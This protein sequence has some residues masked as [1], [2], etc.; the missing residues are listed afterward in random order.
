MCMYMYMCTG[1]LFYDIDNSLLHFKFRFSTQDGLC[2]GNAKEVL[3]PSLPGGL[4]DVGKRRFEDRSRI[5]HILWQNAST[6]SNANSSTS[7]R[8]QGNLSGDYLKAT[9]VCVY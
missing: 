7:K 8:P 3:Q 9:I 5:D 6:G 1:G 2:L 4:P